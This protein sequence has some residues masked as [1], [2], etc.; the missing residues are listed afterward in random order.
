MNKMIKMIEDK[1]NRLCRRTGYRERPYAEV[2]GQVPQ[3][4]CIANQKNC[5]KLQR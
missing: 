3:G 4:I 1:Y 2:Q 5:S